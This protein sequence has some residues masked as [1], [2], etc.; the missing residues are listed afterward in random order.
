[1]IVKARLVSTFVCLASTLSSTFATVI[2]AARMAEICASRLTLAGC[3][4]RDALLSRNPNAPGEALGALGLCLDLEV[5]L[6][7]PTDSGQVLT[8]FRLL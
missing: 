3:T 6:T 1:M 2:P 5:S 7:R 4:L 8:C